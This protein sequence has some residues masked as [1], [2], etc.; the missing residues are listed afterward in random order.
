MGRITDH[1]VLLPVS[2]KILENVFDPKKKKELLEVAHKNFGLEGVDRII[3]TVFTDAETLTLEEE[4]KVR[5]LLLDMTLEVVAVDKSDPT[6]LNELLQRANKGSHGELVSLLLV[7]SNVDFDEQ[8]LD[9]MLDKCP[10]SLCD[11]YDSCVELNDEGQLI[12][13]S[14]QKARFYTKDTSFTQIRGWVALRQ[15]LKKGQRQV[16]THPLMVRLLE[17]YWDRQQYNFYISITTYFILVLLFSSYIIV[18]KLDKRSVPLQILV[19]IFA[20]LRV[21]IE[22]VQFYAWRWRYIK[23]ATNWVEWFVIASSILVVSSSDGFIG[24]RANLASVTCVVAWLSFL[25]LCRQILV[26]DIGV[27]VVM[28]LKITQT[29]FEA[30]PIF[31]LVLFAFG[32]GIWLPLDGALG[33]QFGQVML[34]VYGTFFGDLDLVGT[35]FDDPDSNAMTRFLVLIAMLVLPFLVFNFFVGLA[36]GDISS[37]KIQS[38]LIQLRLQVDVVYLLELLKETKVPKNLAA[39]PEKG[40]KVL[41]KLKLKKKR[42]IK[43]FKSDE[44]S[45][46]RLKMELLQ[47]QLERVTLEL[48]TVIQTIH[49]Q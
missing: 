10:E 15:A 24:W 5:G 14:M 11:F 31:L 30:S 16:L 29:I 47:E 8:L 6:A 38:E 36:V 41:S 20:F 44:N 43:T 18:E 26:F 1:K 35:V 17:F 7:D 46:I 23:D 2:D 3:S 37:V 12:H 39:R 9:E 49:A 34:G 27:Y 21:I 45:Q 25:V 22:S 42:K 28:I 40:G 33:L 48:Q 4:K 13:A 19:Y 32:M